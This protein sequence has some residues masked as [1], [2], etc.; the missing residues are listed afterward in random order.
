MGILACLAAAFAPYRERYTAEA[1]RDTVLTADTVAERLREMCV[2][3]AVA[4]ETI[5]G[6]IGCRASGA[7]GHLRGMAVL[8]EWQGRGLAV[9]LLQMAEGELR[10]SGC[11]RVTLD[12][13]EPLE[14]AARF[15]ER[16]GYAASGRVA[17]FFGM[18]LVEYGKGL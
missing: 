3:V 11:R 17:D 10:R 16:H 14:R 15:Y 18:R 4:E 7:E 12:T 13:T 1:Y 5:A 8:P 2:W 6:T 9:A